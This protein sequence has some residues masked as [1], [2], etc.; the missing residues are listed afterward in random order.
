MSDRI[1]QL[2][3]QRS[4]SIYLRVSGVLALLG[5]LWAWTTSSPLLGRLSAERR[6]SNFQ[7]FVSEL[8]PS[9]VRKGGDASE[10]LPWAW[11][12]LVD[13]GFEA[14]AVTFGIATAAIILSGFFV[15]PFLP[16]SSRELGRRDPF[17]LWSGNS[18]PVIQGIRR[19]SGR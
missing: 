6:W 15:L 14:L 16:V 2:R 9:P 18:S 7:N 3:R 10:A 11:D 17:G 19:V 1:R 12:L 13:G 4:K 5:I 8:V